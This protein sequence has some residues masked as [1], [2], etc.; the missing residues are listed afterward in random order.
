LSET[1]SKLQHW[2]QIYGDGSQTRSFQYVSDLVD[3]LVALMNS[4]YTMPVNLGNPIESTIK[5]EQT[6][7]F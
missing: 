2:P 4:N 7:F 1:F 5:G 3:G 6:P